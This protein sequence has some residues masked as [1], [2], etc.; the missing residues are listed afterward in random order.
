MVPEEIAGVV[1]MPIAHCEW[2]VHN[3][4]ESRHQQ[5]SRQGCLHTQRRIPQLVSLFHDGK[6]LVWICFVQ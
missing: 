1:Y 4:I 6:V 3:I 2:E 5:K